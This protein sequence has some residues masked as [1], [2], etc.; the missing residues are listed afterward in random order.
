MKRY[1]RLSLSWICISIMRGHS[2]DFDDLQVDQL[3]DAEIVVHIAVQVKSIHLIMQPLDLG[4][5]GI[6]NVFAGQAPGKTFKAAHDVEQ[7]G[8]IVLAQLPYARAAVGQELDQS[9][10]R[11][12]F[13]GLAQRRARDAQH[14]AKLTFGNSATVRNVAFD[15]MVAQ[16]RQDLV[17]QG[18]VF[19]AGIRAAGESCRIGIVGNQR[20][21]TWNI[22]SE[23]APVDPKMCAI[24]QLISKKMNAIWFAKQIG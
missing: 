9:F 10:G 22:G 2:W 19:A 21:H 14:L 4:D 5:F 18:L 24:F 20:L 13:Q 6:G 3:I 11:Q 15:D 12:Y 23:R 1:W 17:M 7:F 8:K 16:P